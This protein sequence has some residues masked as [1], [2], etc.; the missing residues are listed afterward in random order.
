MVIEMQWNDYFDNDREA[1]IEQDN[2]NYDYD[3]DDSEDA[4]DRLKRLA[5]VDPEDMGSELDFDDLEDPDDSNYNSV[6]NQ[7]FR[8]EKARKSCAFACDWWN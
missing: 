1:G 8:K 7:R 5:G 4:M 6:A 3:E 2:D